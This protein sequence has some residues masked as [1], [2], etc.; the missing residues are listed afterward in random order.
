MAL[1]AAQPSLVP[2]SGWLGGQGRHRQ[3]QIKAAPGK[4]HRGPR[5]VEIN[6]SWHHGP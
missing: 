2:V 3:P 6:S 5:P 1:P 4:I